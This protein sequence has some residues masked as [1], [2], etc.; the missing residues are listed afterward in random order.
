M[1]VYKYYIVGLYIIIISY[2]CI[3]VLCN[4]YNSLI[5]YIYNIHLHISLCTC[6]I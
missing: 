6:N 4:I 3:L 5:N 2:M 1:Y